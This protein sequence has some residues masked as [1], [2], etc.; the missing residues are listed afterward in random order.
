[1]NATKKRKRSV[2]DRYHHLEFEKP[3]HHRPTRSRPHVLKAH[4]KQ[5]NR[6]THKHR[7]GRLTHIPG[8]RPVRFCRCG[9]Y[10]QLGGAVVV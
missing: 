10:K 3:E 2:L 6:L 8:G 1:M 7:F 9:A 5:T 4:L